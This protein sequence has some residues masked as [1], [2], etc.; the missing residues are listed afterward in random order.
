MYSIST[1]RSR[2]KLEDAVEAAVNGQNHKKIDISMRR[3]VLD[4][5][6][7]PIESASGSVDKLLFMGEDVTNKVMAERQLLQDNKMIAVGQLAAGVAH[8][9]K[10]SAG[11]NKELLLCAQEYE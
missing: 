4:I 9:D 1:V 5:D 6:I 8:D 7:F 10:E 11:Y 3:K 2:Q